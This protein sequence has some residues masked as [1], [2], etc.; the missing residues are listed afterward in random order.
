MKKKIVIS[1]LFFLATFIPVSVHA[2]AQGEELLRAE[3]IEI[4]D[5]VEKTENNAVFVQQNLLLEGSEGK[6][7]GQ[8]ITVEGISDIIVIRSNIYEVGDRVVL[9]ESVGPDGNATYYVVDYVRTPTLFWL[10]TLFVAIVI[11]IS[12]RKGI[13][14]LIVLAVTFLLI[15]YY[16]IPRILDGGS[17]VLHSVLTGLV[18]LALAIFFT[19]GFHQRS[20]VAFQS[21]GISLI[22]IVVLSWFFTHAAHLTGLASDD[23]MTLLGLGNENINLQGLLLAGMIIGALG[24]LDDIVMSQVSLVWE[25]AGTNQNLG[26]MQIYNKAMRVG[27]DHINAIIN[28]LF[29]AYAGVALPLLVIFTFTE[30]PFTTIWDILNNE[31]IATEIVRTLVGSIVLVLTVPVATWLAARSFAGKVSQEEAHA[32]HHH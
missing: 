6:I 28:T 12:G 24:V 10:T 7:D 27:V 15:L 25:L 30:P 18:I 8:R 9:S 5:Q 4:L 14:A 3:V 13:R 21:I 22:F 16:L 29:L 1:F 11:A 2:Q 26:A 31:V 17:P 23:A 32:G 19:E 20:K